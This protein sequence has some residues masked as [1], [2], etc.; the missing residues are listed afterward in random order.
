MAK[1]EALGV[2]VGVGVEMGVAEGE[3][4]GVG[5]STRF[6][7]EGKLLLKTSKTPANQNLQRKGVMSARSTTVQG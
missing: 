3:G 6:T 4:L 1:G 2:G 7:F 5:K